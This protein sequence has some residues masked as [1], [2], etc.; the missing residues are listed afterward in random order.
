MAFPPESLTR[1]TIDACEAG[2][3]PDPA[4]RWGIRLLLRQRLREA[5]HHGEYGA[6]L[7]EA[8]RKLPIATH[9]AE[10]NEQHYEVPAGFFEQMLGPRLKYSACVFES[11]D[12]LAS[13]EERTLALTCERGQLEDG[14]RV[15]DLG[16]GWGSL[17]LWIAEH[18]PGTR[19]TAVSNSTGQRELIEARARERGL[20]NLAVITGAPALDVVAYNLAME[21]LDGL[22]TLA[23]NQMQLAIIELGDVA[24]AVFNIG[25]DLVALDIGKDVGLQNAEVNALKI[26]HI[27]NA[28]KRAMADHRQD[29][30]FADLVQNG[31]HV[32]GDRGAGATE[33]LGDDAHGAAVHR[34]FP[35]GVALR[36]QDRI[37]RR[38]W[39]DLKHSHDGDERR[40][41][42][43]KTTSELELPHC[44]NLLSSP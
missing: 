41:D 23:G 16:C 42:G 39:R 11:G 7:A 20:E 13:A 3:V 9:T 35:L 14:M 5:A 40:E 6:K 27:G 25:V 28:L 31:R 19:I 10:A 34:V 12:D 38:G 15:L 22:D 8:M 36:F 24:H 43:G 21:I 26:H 32:G 29:A 2:W 37:L 4:L 30:K 44:Q 17:S 33:A 1:Y 18:Y